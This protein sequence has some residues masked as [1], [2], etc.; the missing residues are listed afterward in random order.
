MKAQV[1]VGI[2][3]YPCT[4]IQ[5]EESIFSEFLL[6]CKTKGFYRM[7]KGTGPYPIDFKIRGPRR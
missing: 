6:T 3:K 1:V 7:S 4:G 5:G 2:K